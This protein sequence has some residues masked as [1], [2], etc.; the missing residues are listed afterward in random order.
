M[1]QTTKNTCRVWTENDLPFDL[2]HVLDDVTVNGAISI[3]RPNRPRIVISVEAEISP[4]QEEQL[5]LQ[6]QQTLNNPQMKWFDS[7]D[8]LVV[9]LE[10]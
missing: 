3:V 4:E 9:N 8:E 5:V 2:V 1:Q 6:G 7:V 10:L